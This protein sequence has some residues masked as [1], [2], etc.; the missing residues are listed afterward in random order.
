MKKFIAENI[1]VTGYSHKLLQKECQDYSFCWEE[2]NYD[3]VIVC[4][5]HGGD[6][7]IRSAA[8]SRMACEAGHK[9][10][11]E[12]MSVLKKDKK[13]KN[14]FLKDDKERDK[15]LA[16]L[17]RAVIQEWNE[18]IANDLA[19]ASIENDERYASLSDA[20]KLDIMHNNFKAY[21]STFIA[22]VLTERFYVILKLGDGNVCLV[23]GGGRTT[24]AEKYFEWLKDDNL[25]FNLTTSLC[26][27][28]ADMDFRYAF[29]KYDPNELHG[30]ILTSDGVINSYT[31]KDSYLK[32]IKN[33]YLSFSKRNKND[34]KTELAD[35]LDTLSEK[36]SGDDV[37]IA[38][39]CR[40][41]K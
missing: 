30:I 41:R 4:D 20:D 31:S 23:H 37:S 17:C 3:A 25:Q 27:E 15:M 1:T 26:S 12:F 9:V 32:L 34:A 22:A 13:F 21:G 2:D 6:K 7:Y 11:S 24:L 36:G 16:Q 28:N 39:V 35:F 14:K 8:G 18:R 10:I 33:V 29:S 40:K 38:V 5:G 19:V